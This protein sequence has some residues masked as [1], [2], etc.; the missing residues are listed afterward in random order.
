MNLLKKIISVVLGIC[1]LLSMTACGAAGNTQNQ[2]TEPSQGPEPEAEQTETAA[3]EAKKP[4]LLVVSFGTSYNETRDATIGAIEADL[5][6]AYPEYE[7]RRAFTSQIIIDILKEREGLEIDNVTEAME[8]LVADG[9]RDVVIQPTHVMPG[10]EYN[11]I[12]DEVSEYASKF[13]SL[14]ISNPLLISDEDYDAVVASLVEETAQY[15]TE[16]TAIVFMGHGTEHEANAAYERLQKRLNAA[17][18]SNYFVGTVEGTPTV[19]DVLEG[20]RASEAQRVVLLPLMI[21][22]GDHANNDMAGDEE[23]SWKTIFSNA[24]F[25]VECVLKGMGEYAGIRE[26]LVSHARAA[27]EGQ[28]DV[29]LVVSFGTSYYETR[30]NTIDAIE[31]DIRAAYPDYE[32]RR[33][34][35]AQTIINILEKRDGY[36]IENVTQALERMVQEGVKNVILQPTHVMTGYEYDDMVAEASKFEGKFDS[37]KISRPVLVEDADYE[38]L[39]SVLAE[40]TEAYN[41]DGTAVVFMGHGTEHEANATYT[42]LQAQFHLAGYRNYYIGTVEATPSVE[43]VLE[44]VKATDASKVVLL[45]LMIVAGDHANNDMAGDEEDSWK[46]IFTQ[47]GY[48]VECVLRGMGSYS[49]VRQMILDHLSDT[50]N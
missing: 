49:G 22:A 25:E 6:A 11:D 42:K 5:Q 36:N 39:V 26:L 27:M 9:V 17:G 16:G 31:Q 33:A 50:I 45:P 30:K 15:N 8:R 10:Y 35:T 19:E 14:T 1:L 18:Y 24:G 12:V 40:E 37:L 23:D 47:A 43:D 29:I 13:D 32:V 20:V 3:T 34:F 2:S 38:T 7:V 48:E 4:V 41:A 28:K 46:T 44:A 21:V